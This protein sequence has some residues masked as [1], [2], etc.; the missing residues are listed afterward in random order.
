MFA[1]AERAKACKTTRE[2]GQLADRAIETL[3]NVHSE[4]FSHFVAG[5]QAEEVARV[6]AE[7][8]KAARRRKEKSKPK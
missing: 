8:F 4:I 3:E 5:G 2:D 6:N 1:C 7:K